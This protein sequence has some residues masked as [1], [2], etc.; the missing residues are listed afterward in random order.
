MLCLRACFCLQWDN[1][2]YDCNID[3]RTGPIVVNWYQGGRTNVTYSCLDRWVA[4]GRGN[5]VAFIW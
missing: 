5:Q 2:H 3:M 1:Q 4:A